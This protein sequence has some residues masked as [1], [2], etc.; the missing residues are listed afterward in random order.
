MSNLKEIRDRITSISSTMQITNAMKMV[1]ASKLK[2]SQNSLRQ[3]LLY[4][5][6]IEKIFYHICRL[7][8]KSIFSHFLENRNSKTILF[9]VISSNRGLCGSFN[10]SIVKKIQ[11]IIKKKYLNKKI[12]ILSFGQKVGDILIKS[13]DIFRNKNFIWNNLNFFQVDQIINEVI[14]CYFNNDFYEIILVYNNFQ[15][16]TTQTVV[17]EQLLPIQ[18]I[19][20]KSFHS[21]FSYILEPNKEQIIKKIIPKILTIRLYKALL[22]SQQSENT[23]RMIAMHQATENAKFIQNALVLEYNKLRQSAITKEILEIISGVKAL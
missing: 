4:H 10:S 15:N 2:K 18:E 11:Y 20:I 23:A 12:K 17:V 9:I 6:K 8:N 1:S 5:D 13:Y 19:E 22:Q 7:V 21:S 16:F 14:S 3:L